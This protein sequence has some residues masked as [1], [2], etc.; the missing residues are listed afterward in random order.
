MKQ[1]EPDQPSNED[2]LS[3]HVEERSDEELADYDKGFEAG[4]AGQPNDD[5][6]SFAWQRGWAEA[7]E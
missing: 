7:Q 5:T 2:D 3:F 4:Q 1:R 6:K